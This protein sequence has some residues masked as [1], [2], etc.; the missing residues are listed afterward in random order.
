MVLSDDLIDFLKTHFPGQLSEIGVALDLL[1]CSLNNAG[2]AITARGNEL[3]NSKEF[4]EAIEFLKRANELDDLSEQMQS[5]IDA[6]QLNDI[7]VVSEDEKLEV[8]EN[9]YP[10]YE[11]Y[12]VDTAIAHTLY[13]DF[14]HKRPY[15]FMLK[16]KKVCVTEWT[17]VL[18]E[19]CNQL[20]EIDKSLIKEFPDEPKL[21]GRKSKY[22]TF[23]SPELMRAPKKLNDL[24][25]YVETHFSANDIRNLIIKMLNYYNISLSEYR[26]YLRADYNILH[27]KAESIEDLI[28]VVT[29]DGFANK[30][31]I[32]KKAAHDFTG[33]CIQYVGNYLNVHTTQISKAKYATP[34]NRLR[35]VCLI[36]SERDTDKNP[37][38]W[39]GFRA[40]QKEFLEGAQE[41]YVALGCGS[42]NLILL[43]PY[44][45]FCEWLNYMSSTGAAKNIIHW[46]VI[47]MREKGSLMLRLKL[48]CPKVNI[49]EYIIRA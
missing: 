2:E 36:S 44:S 8:I 12:E 43:I 11:R 25:L 32:Q 34:D 37:Y 5:L 35:I 27:S 40:K 22:F 24:G 17:K 33:Q 26:I 10:N 30:Q 45:K 9:S 3:S 39:F 28:E 29:L 41:S 48:G 19:T 31:K 47:V 49:T 14:I 23:E 42:E 16:N 38:F 13:D 21:N 7:A 4:A 1:I 46:H 6:H 18:V 15:A 20:N